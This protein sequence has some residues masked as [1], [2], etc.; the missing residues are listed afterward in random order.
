LAPA[1]MRGSSAIV[2]RCSAVCYCSSHYCGCA[3]GACGVTSVHLEQKLKTV[4][5]PSA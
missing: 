5:L 4:S 1:K 2:L 3:A